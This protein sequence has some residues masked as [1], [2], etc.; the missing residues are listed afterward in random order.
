MVAGLRIQVSR[1]S[2]MAI[3]RKIRGIGLHV[4]FGCIGRLALLRHYR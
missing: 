1:L 2:F 3:P 4:N